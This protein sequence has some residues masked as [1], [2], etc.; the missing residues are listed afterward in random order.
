MYAP[1]THY[2]AVGLYNPLSRSNRNVVVCVHNPLSRSDRNVAVGVYD[3]LSRSDRNV[4]VGVYNPLSRSNRNVAVCVHNPLSGSKRNVQ[5][6]IN[7]SV[8]WLCKDREYRW[9]TRSFSLLPSAELQVTIPKQANLGV[10]TGCC[11]V[12]ICRNHT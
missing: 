1:T 12:Y 3:P 10:Y 4:A 5:T 2:V 11:S 8:H 6:L 7:G 9:G